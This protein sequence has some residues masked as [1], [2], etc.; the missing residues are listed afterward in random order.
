MKNN[1]IKS[2]ELTNKQISINEELNKLFTPNYLKHD[3]RN[4]ISD[5]VSDK[6]NLDRGN[7]KEMFNNSNKNKKDIFLDLLYQTQLSQKDNIQ[8]KGNNKEV[9][10]ISGK[11]T[12][13]DEL[14]SKF[15]YEN[16]LL[17]DKQINPTNN[18]YEV[19]HYSTKI[20]EHVENNSIQYAIGKTSSEV[21]IQ[22]Y[23]NEKNGQHRKPNNQSNDALK[24]D[25]F[26]NDMTFNT[27]GEK[28]RR[29]GNIGHKYLF[30]SKEYETFID[31]EDN[32]N[33]SSNLLMKRHK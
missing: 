30:R 21:K 6:K 8:D 32:I 10:N 7:N 33:D 20:P 28:D 19:Y 31:E 18:V 3:I 17:N 13:N 29:T 26:E 9:N 4:V 15:I 14:Q 23:D 12:S 2:T 16:S 25:N 5:F 1:E 27:S 11:S 22:N 24:P